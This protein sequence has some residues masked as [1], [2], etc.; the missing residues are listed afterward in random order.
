MRYKHAHIHLNLGT[1][2]H[3]CIAYKQVMAHTNRDEE[4]LNTIKGNI[5]L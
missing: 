4:K 2:A 5:E 3:V 1:Y